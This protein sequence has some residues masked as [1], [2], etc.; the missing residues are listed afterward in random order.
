MEFTTGLK[1]A[2]KKT[3]QSDVKVTI[4]GSPLNKKE[5][6]Y[7]EKVLKEQAQFFEASIRGL[8]EQSL[9][10]TPAGSGDL[11]TVR[12][13]PADQGT[14]MAD[15]DRNSKVADLEERQLDEIQFALRR[16]RLGGYGLCIDCGE[17]IPRQRLDAIPWTAYDIQCQ[18]ELEKNPHAEE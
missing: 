7:F 4:D 14:L 5:L 8:D 16:I 2:N 1:S 15:Q 11:N 12:T 9:M 18:A 10:D 17:P 3:N 13:H 6:A